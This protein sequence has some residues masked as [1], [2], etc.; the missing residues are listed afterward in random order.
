MSLVRGIKSS[1]MAGGLTAGGLAGLS[2]LTGGMM[3][4][5][6]M[7]VGVIAGL[8]MAVSNKGRDGSRAGTS[9]AMVGG[10]LSV[11]GFM[12]VSVMAGNHD[13]LNPFQ[14]VVDMGPV[15]VMSLVV[16]ACAAWWLGGRE[17]PISQ[18]LAQQPAVQRV[19]EALEGHLGAIS[20]EVDNSK[21]EKVKKAA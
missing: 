17:T 12:T 10:L 14:A 6:P 3:S 15:G 9:A 1:A 21:R 4:M 8:G 19:S 20:R 13:A 18:M 5:A 16:G 11:A 7:A 2:I